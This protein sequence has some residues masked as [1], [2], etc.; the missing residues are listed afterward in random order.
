MAIG[1]SPP[2]SLV[3]VVVI[4]FSFLPVTHFECVY[5]EKKEQI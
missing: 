2:L 1:K 5:L 4:G 3:V